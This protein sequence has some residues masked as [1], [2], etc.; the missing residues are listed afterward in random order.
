MLPLVPTFL[1]ILLPFLLPILP[2]LL[3]LL[4]PFFLPFLLATLPAFAATAL[5]SVPAPL[6]AAPLSSLAHACSFRSISE[7]ATVFAT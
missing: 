2:E 1:T 7:F 4:L 5:T 3:T 6:V